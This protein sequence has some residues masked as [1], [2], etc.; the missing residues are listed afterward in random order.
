MLDEFFCLNCRK[1]KPLSLKSL[2][3]IGRYKKEQVCTACDKRAEKRIATSKKN[4]EE[5]S[6]FSTLKEKHRAKVVD[7]HA[8]KSYA[9]DRFYN[10]MKN[11]DLL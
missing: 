8:K 5:L 2:R 7:N 10:Y 1:Y 3:K 9:N 4:L 6:G 11:S